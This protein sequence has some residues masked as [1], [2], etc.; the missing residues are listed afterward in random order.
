MNMQV[1]MAK[2]LTKS[3]MMN[4]FGFEADDLHTLPPAN[5]KELSGYVWRPL[6]NPQG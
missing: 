4:H 1:E 3:E 2:T 6:R 5:A